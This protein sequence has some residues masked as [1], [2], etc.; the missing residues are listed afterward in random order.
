MNRKSEERTNIFW[1]SFCIFCCVA[2]GMTIAF[3]CY[4]WVTISEYEEA[5]PEN[6]VKKQLDDW[7]NKTG[8]EVI[9]YPTLTE[10]EFSDEEIVKEVYQDILQTAPL[11][12]RFVK[13]D[14][15]TGNKQYHIYADN[16]LLG[17]MTLESIRQQKRLGFLQ[18]NQMQVIKMEPVLDVMV[19][20]YDICLLSNQELWLNQKKVKDS[21]LVGEPKRIKELEYLYEYVPLPYEVT[22]HIDHLYE[23]PQIQIIDENKKEV[24]Y[25]E[26]QNQI[27]VNYYPEVQNEIPKEILAKIDVLEAAKTWSLFT[28][29]DLKGANYG[30]K[31]VRNYFVK[32][33]YLWNKLGEYAK[34]VDITFVSD[35]YNTYFDEEKV[36]EYQS[37]TE[38]CFSCRIQFTKHMTLRTGKSQVDE[39][40]SYFYFVYIDDTDDGIDNPAWKIADIQASI[41]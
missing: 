25:Q 15:A 41:E 14:Y 27:Q 40:D 6:V 26:Y 3:L 9:T 31:T 29:K 11:T 1:P 35:H 7:K 36:S 38:N 10:S 30:L 13:D 32:D 19:W 39:T 28:T 18:I 37:Y 2:V 5:R 23:K 34:G 24:S 4:V 21:Y 22:Y 17:K 12:Y 20:D 8:Y 33:S 16:E